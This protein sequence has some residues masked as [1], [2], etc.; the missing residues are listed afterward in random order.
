MTGVSGM[1]DEGE[2]IGDW[3]MVGSDEQNVG[4]SG[5]SW[6]AVDLQFGGVSRT[7]PSGTRGAFLALR[8]K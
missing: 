1:E 7:K 2:D 8:V 5:W 4:D 6:I 3:E